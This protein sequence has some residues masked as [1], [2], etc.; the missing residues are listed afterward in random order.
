SVIRSQAIPDR[1]PS[2][3][4]N[5]Y[6]FESRNFNCINVKSHMGCDRFGAFLG[7]ATLTRAFNPDKLAD[8]RGEIATLTTVGVKN[9]LSKRSETQIKD[10][11]SECDKPLDFLDDI[12]LFKLMVKRE[13]KVKLD[14]SCMSK[15]SPAQNIIFHNK[16]V[17]LIFSPI[18]DTIKS[19][20]LYCLNPNILFYV[21]MN[22]EELAEWVYRRIGGED[23]YYKA[24]LDFSKFDKS[25]DFYIKAYERFMYQAFGFDPELLDIW[26][27]G[28]YHCRAMSRDR[29]LAFTL[30]AQRRSGGSNTWI[31][32]TLVTLGLLCMY[33]DLSKANAVLL[34]GDDSIIF[35]SREIPDT[36][37][38]IITDTGF[39]TKFIRDA[40]AYFCSKFIVFCG[41]YV[42][43]SPDPY[44]L[45][46][47]LGKTLNIRSYYELYE[48]YI[49]F[50][51]VTRDYD[52]GVFIENL[53]PLVS[54]RYKCPLSEVYPALCSIH[55]ARANFKKFREIYPRPSGYTLV[56]GYTHLILLLKHGYKVYEERKV[57]KELRSYVGFAVQMYLPDDDCQKLCD[58]TTLR[59]QH[60]RISYLNSS[61]GCK[62]KKMSKLEKR[63]ARKLAVDVDYVSN[64]ICAEYS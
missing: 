36:S 44:K 16:V 12:T 30:S 10:L 40:P 4:E 55:C 48:R 18:F 1:T 5:L 50:R 62:E 6:S 19:R 27:E 20:I 49:S 43:F 23:I 35:H 53:A 26:M 34:S 57:A 22:E 3:Q 13:A 45:C 28:E 56:R 38:E 64:R 47:R 59:A 2:W 58:L 24:E 60:G 51:D 17:N 41:D 9:F 29:D 25:Q 31:G 8:L 46:V 54:R 63:S 14:S 21:D 15:H 32:N 11:L 37:E 33:Y 7:S 42:C 61:R 39:E 52:D